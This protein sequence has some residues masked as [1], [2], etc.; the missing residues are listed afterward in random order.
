MMVENNKI[1]T[2]PLVSIIV[3]TYNSSNYVLETLE[4]AKVQTYKKIE[5]IISDDCSTDDTVAVCEAW[6]KENKACF[7]RTKLITVKKNTGIP[8][9]CN[10]GLYAAKGEWV[11]TIA[12]DDA[13]MINCIKDNIAFVQS[14]TDIQFCFSDYEA[15]LNTFDTENL[16]VH[17]EYYLENSKKFSQL[18]SKFQIQVLARGSVLNAPSFFFKKRE[19][20]KIGGYNETF[21]EMEDWSTFFDI[22]KAKYKFYFLPIKTVKYRL[23]SNSISRIKDAQNY[24]FSNFAL[25]TESMIKNNFYKY[26]TNKEKILFYL[27]YSYYKFYLKR[28]II[29]IMDKIIRRI[30]YYFVVLS[31]NERLKS[32]DKYYKKFN[33]IGLK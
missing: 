11:K 8:K 20:L 31:L 12:G 4:S 17:K 14:N 30:W 16:K 15:Y 9:N 19:I 25:K 24:E 10:R 23:H 18:N 29:N 3:I 1:V 13:L 21:K 27:E 6:L 33:K 32:L 22:L 26:Y 5:L 2:T 7:E 28:K